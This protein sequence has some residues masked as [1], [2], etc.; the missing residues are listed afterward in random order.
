[1]AHA[2]AGGSGA[3]GNERDDGLGVGASVVLEE[4]LG[5]LLLHRATNLTD[6]DDTLGLGVV[7]EDLDDVNVLGAGEGVTANADGEGLA[8]AGE[9]GLAGIVS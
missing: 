3:A 9:G 4:V 2:T 6:E 5:S 7:E 1:V 8:E